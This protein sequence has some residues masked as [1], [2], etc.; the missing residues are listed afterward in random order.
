MSYLE[1]FL[2]A[3]GLCFDTF[4][5]SLMGGIC[6]QRR[7]KWWEVCKIIF[8]FGFFQAGFTFLGWL[9]GYSVSSYI[10]KI[11]HWVAFILL[12]YIGGKMVWESFSKKGEKDKSSSDNTDLLNIKQL[13]TLSIATSI[14]ALAVG[15]SLAMIDLPGIK[16]GIEELMILLVTSIASAIG[17]FSGKKLGP[18][19]GKHS[20]LVGG[21][22]LIL[23][24]VKI[25]LEHLIS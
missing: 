2:L 8:C 5:V 25:L 7:L 3:V 22:I 17:L 13:I 19:F 21:I 16:V 10:E 4:A 9:L 1:L 24:G 14:D 11:D 20:E 12:C 15:I 18:K 6:L 23:I